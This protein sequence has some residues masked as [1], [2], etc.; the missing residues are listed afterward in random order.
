MAYVFVQLMPEMQES[1]SAFVKATS[2][3]LPYEGM[4][5]YFLAL[6]GFMGFYGLDNLRT[7]ARDGGNDF[8]LHL[9][10]FGLYVALMSYLLVHGLELPSSA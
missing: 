10:G 4:A 1:R 2:I 9:A 3:P 8:S 5:V 6:M 7:Q